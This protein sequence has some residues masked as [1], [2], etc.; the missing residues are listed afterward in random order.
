[1]EFCVVTT[2][3]GSKKE[4][5]R[6]AR[7][8]RRKFNGL[9]REK[10]GFKLR[11]V[12]DGAL[13]SAVFE[14]D[15]TAYSFVKRSISIREKLSIA[16]AEYVITEKE[17]DI[18]RRLVSKE[19]GFP[20]AEEQNVVVDSC[21]HLLGPEMEGAEVRS[22][23]CGQLA[24]HLRNYMEEH[25]ELNLDGFITFRMK[26]YLDHIRET[27]DY[28]VD[29]YLL[30]KQYE[31]F[32]GLL[33]YFVH[34]QETQIGVVHLMHKG[35]SDFTIYNEHMLPL[36]AAVV[37][38]VVARIADHELELEDVIVSSLISLS[39][40]R[41]VVHTREPEVQIISTIRQIFAERI[42]MCAY[43]PRCKAFLE[44]GRKQGNH[45]P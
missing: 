43:C 5:E 14:G 3:A 22:R 38:G 12:T 17:A 25:T 44:G 21:L 9:H 28:V 6:F 13:V 16:L 37:G 36:E 33:K 10:S 20:D 34:F 41:I 30:D 18:V 2:A 32:I 15:E 8:I 40:G 4:A 42:E 35:G 24:V 11:F 29:E 31:E 1:M 26:E 27:L 39:P 7:L 23:R 45:G 19:Y